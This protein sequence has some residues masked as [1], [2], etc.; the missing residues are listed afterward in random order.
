[1][2]ADAGDVVDNARDRVGL[3]WRPEIGSSILEHFD[4]IDLIE[5][6]PENFLE[7][8][9]HEIDGFR[10]LGRHIPVMVHALSLGLASRFPVRE[11]LLDR[12]ARVVDFLEPEAWSEHLA[13]V[14]VPGIE[15]GHLAAPPW[16]EETIDGAVRNIRRAAQA[17]GTPP[18]LE[19]IATLYSPPGSTMTEAEWTRL[20]L[21]QSSTSLLLDLENVYANATNQIRLAVTSLDSLPINT[22]RYIHI[23]GGQIT[24]A[25]SDQF[26]LDD[27][28]HDTPVAVYDLLEELA[29]RVT[30]PLS[31]ILERDGH[32]PAFHVL[33]NELQRAREAISRGRARR[34]E[35]A[36]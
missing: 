16:S 25:N 24:Q 12:I 15:L 11:E 9:R 31:V 17:V 29:S 6:T 32:Y 22:A 13:F 19:N 3:G 26:Y 21:D 2:G 27:H 28:H 7:L 10:E 8:P 20:I 23:S 36:Q 5:V 33:L 18:Y 35:C 30:I 14:R 4:S 34:L 1:V